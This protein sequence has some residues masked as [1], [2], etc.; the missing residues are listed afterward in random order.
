MTPTTKHER[1]KATELRQW[2]EAEHEGLPDE[3]HG[4]YPTAY[5]K[6]LDEWERRCAIAFQQS[7]PQSPPDDYKARL[8]EFRNR[9]PGPP[10]PPRPNKPTPYA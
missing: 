2:F 7:A 1:E 9:P 10:D 5:A 8:R 6:L 4:A 3:D